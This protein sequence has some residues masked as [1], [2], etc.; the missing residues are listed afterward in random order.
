MQLAND[1]ST[2][3]KKTF[4]NLGKAC[5][6]LPIDIN[7]SFLTSTKTNIAID[8][9]LSFKFI[10]ITIPFTQQILFEKELLFG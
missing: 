4:A 2:I 6:N 1:K 8:P 3:Y 9:F 7:K 5:M 10:L